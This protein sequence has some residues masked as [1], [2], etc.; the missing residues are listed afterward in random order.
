MEIFPQP[1]IG[2]YS[3]WVS[4]TKMRA[5]CCNVS[6]YVPEKVTLGKVAQTNS[7][8]ETRPSSFHF[9]AWKLN[10]EP[11][12]ESP[13][14][15]YW[16][17]Q[18]AATISSPHPCS[19]PTTSTSHPRPVVYL[20]WWVLTP[21]VWLLWTASSRFPHPLASSGFQW[22]ENSARDGR[23]KEE[24]IG[25]LLLLILLCMGVMILEGAVSFHDTF[26]T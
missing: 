18:C 9:L 22:V 15:L 7:I 17:S 2:Q 13:W 21:R 3:L 10:R 25:V 6:Q 23:A 11:H 1:L 14:S 19:L 24:R 26:S 16:L 4:K 20:P 12:F 8:R 5:K